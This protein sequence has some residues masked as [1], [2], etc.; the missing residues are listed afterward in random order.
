M[1]GKGIHEIK[2][3]SLEQ[4]LRYQEQYLDR[5][6]SLHYNTFQYYDLDIG[7]FTV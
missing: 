2:H 3:E 1:W 6:D 4:N 7:R 5:E